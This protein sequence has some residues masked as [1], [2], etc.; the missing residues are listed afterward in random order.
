MGQKSI[1]TMITIKKETCVKILAASHNLLKLNRLGNE[2]LKCS[3]MNKELF[4]AFLKTTSICL[5]FSP[6]CPK[7]LVESGLLSAIL[8][9]TVMS[10]SSTPASGKEV[11][12]YLKNLLINTIEDANL[13]EKRIECEI[14]YFFYCLKKKNDQEGK[15][16]SK[17][18][19]SISHSKL[20]NSEEFPFIEFQ[21]RFMAIAKEHT[22]AFVKVLNRICIITK[23]V[24]NEEAKPPSTNPADKADKADKAS[25]PPKKLEFIKLA[26]TS[27]NE[28]SDKK[29][30][31]E[32]SKKAVSILLLELITNFLKE[33]NRHLERVKLSLNTPEDAQDNQLHEVSML[34]TKMLLEIVI[35]KV[36][37][38]NPI[39]MSLL[40]AY[41][42]SKALASCKEPILK[43]RLSNFGDSLSFVAFMV[44]GLLW[45]TPKLTT[46]LWPLLSHCSVLVNRNGKIKSINV[47]MRAEIV[48][49]VRYAIQI[50][51]NQ[52]IGFIRKVKEESKT[53]PLEEMAL[54]MSARCVTELIASLSQDYLTVKGLLGSL[55]GSEIVLA[56]GILDSLESLDDRF[57][58]QVK[59][60]I[61]LICEPIGLLYKYVSLLA[62]NKQ[63][64]D[65]IPEVVLQGEKDRKM[66]S[67]ELTSPDSLLVKWP[68]YASF[69]AYRSDKHKKEA[70]L[71]SPEIIF[72]QAEVDSIKKDSRGVRRRLESGDLDDFAGG[73][74]LPRTMLEMHNLRVGR[75][76]EEERPPLPQP[77][78]E[79]SFISHDNGDHDE[80][81]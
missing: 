18:E 77:V 48:K 62:I 75:G 44:R 2:R 38:R 69:K 26:T 46:H 66:A 49:E 6:D 32:V 67:V 59:P 20:E 72:S 68:L 60:L 39:L 65:A 3:L 12:Q 61:D 50:L 63:A 56:K 81:V 4:A 54:C 24:N 41:D 64:I 23:K 73:L 40:Q 47:L 29:E 31:S 25:K 14:R 76:Q 74:L 70:T 7:K 17:E 71:A 34:S 30:I 80:E 35:N 36:V 22:D 1:E 37:A 51:Q 79:D 11:S 10:K 9:T 45:L 57:A 53:D 55:D 16:K 58:S 42:C 52:T 8:R 15:G 5:K 43:E 13:I 78:Q 19:G 21:D 27:T 28:F 33:C